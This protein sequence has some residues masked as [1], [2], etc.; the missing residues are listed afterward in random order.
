MHPSVLIFTKVKRWMFIADSTRPLS[1]NKAESDLDD[2]L[3][4]LRWLAQQNLF[5]NFMGYP[6]KPKKDLLPG[7]ELLYHRDDEAR[8]LLHRVMDV[9][10]LEAVRRR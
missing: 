4:I 1:A 7:F 8:Q 6:E 2:I 5:L 10:D 9:T 3:V